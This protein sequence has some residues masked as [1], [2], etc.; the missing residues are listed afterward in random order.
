MSARV[1][2]APPA[3]PITAHYSATVQALAFCTATFWQYSCMYSVAGTLP[4]PCPKGPG[5]SRAGRSFCVLCVDY[6]CRRMTLALSCR[7]TGAGGR[8]TTTHE[9][10]RT[11]LVRPG[12]WATITSP[13]WSAKPPL[14]YLPRA[15][16][17]RKYRE[18]RAGQGYS[19][20]AGL[21]AGAPVTM[22]AIGNS[23]TADRLRTWPRASDDAN[24]LNFTLKFHEK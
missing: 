19:S 4:G 9:E 15:A 2:T 10:T 17:L 24:T 14:I 18:M 20:G 22:P 12:P 6:L 7:G 11:S 1:R 16:R 23:T 3:C 21:H 13:S 5:D 8:D